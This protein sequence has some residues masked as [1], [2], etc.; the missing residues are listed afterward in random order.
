MKLSRADLFKKLNDGQLEE[1]E[2]VEFKREWNQDCGKSFSSIGNGNQEGWMIIGIED[3]GVI[4]DSSNQQ[5]KEQK[6]QIENHITEYLEP[7]STVQSISIQSLEEKYFIVIEIIQPNSIVSWNQKY[8][9]RTGTRNDQMSDGERKKIE[10]ERPGFDFSSLPY[11]EDINSSLVL[12]FANFL[13]KDNGDWT[14]SS[15]DEILSKLNMKNKN[16][17]G[18]LFGN[19]SFRLVH[20]KESFE[21]LD[22]EETR[23]LYHLLQKDFTQHI[24]SWTRKRSI[25][26]KSDS[27]SVEE[28]EPYSNNALREVLVNAVAHSAFEHHGGNVKVELYPNRIKVSNYCS[29]E[30]EAFIKKK[31]SSQSSSPN[32]FLMKILR[33]ASLSEELGTG[34]NKI[35]KY[36]I[37]AGKREPLFEYDNV[38]NY[39]IWSV[40]LYNEEHD[41]N[42]LDLLKVLRNQYED[43]IDKY[44]VSAALVLWRGKTLSEILSYMDDHHKR[45]TADILMEESS[46]FS[47]TSK[48]SDSKDMKDFKVN[49]KRWGRLKLEGQTSK[50]FSK[51]EETRIKEDLREYA[52]AEKRDGY[53]TNRE[54]RRILKLS[55][56]KSEQV[57]VSQLF[58][59]WEREGFLERGEKRGIWRIKK[60]F[61]EEYSSLVELFDN[62]RKDL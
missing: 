54:T 26:L 32:I 20:Y 29:K 11:A 19:F 28:E 21:V 34:R 39:G 33:Q 17:S 57:Q 30:A 58:Q 52:Y 53:I 24:Q 2:L 41:K 51:P 22:Q 44:R 7:S 10:L 12:D 36:V 37:E 47:I 25:A 14:K 62:L 40:T 59:K 1:S 8:Y 49:L 6:Q 16:A 18:I 3:N 50:V 46:P 60:S 13:P 45:L 35:F 61:Y 23:G 38:K 48:Q 4:I 43:Q 15:S 42:L 9:K 55:D 31:F 5:I 56:S 27:L